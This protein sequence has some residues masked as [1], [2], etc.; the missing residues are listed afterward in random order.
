MTLMASPVYPCVTLNDSLKFALRRTGKLGP[1]HRVLFTKDDV[2]FLTSLDE[3]GVVGVQTLVD[4]IS[5]YDLV[6]VW[7]Q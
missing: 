6:E 5:K 7:L 4:M 1:L 2:P 3:A